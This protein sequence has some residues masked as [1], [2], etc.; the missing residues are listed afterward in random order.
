MP[1][2]VINGVEY[3]FSTEEWELYQRC[4]QETGN[5]AGCAIEHGSP[6]EEDSD[7]EVPPSRERIRG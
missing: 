4:I 1:T 3:V 5:R 7:E 2:E 6:Q